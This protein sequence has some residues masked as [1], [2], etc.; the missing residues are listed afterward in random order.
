A[1]LNQHR[2]QP[3]LI[4]PSILRARPTSVGSQSSKLLDPSQ[5]MEQYSCKYRVAGSS[6]PDNPAGSKYVICTFFKTDSGATCFLGGRNRIGS[7]RWH[8]S[9]AS[10]RL[11]HTRLL[12]THCAQSRMA[13]RGDH[14]WDRS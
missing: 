5:F 9:K 10:V 3:V 14:F 4:V 1:L 7:L 11:A 13:A 2:T 8:N 6:P 12:S